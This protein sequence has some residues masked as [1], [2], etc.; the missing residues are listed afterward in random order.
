MSIVTRSAGTHPSSG[1][2]NNKNEP[3]KNRRSSIV[4]NGSR[5]IARCTCCTICSK[6][7]AM[8]ITKIIESHLRRSMCSELQNLRYCTLGTC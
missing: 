5:V 3:E 2:K 8:N 4:G 1:Q 6:E 7:M